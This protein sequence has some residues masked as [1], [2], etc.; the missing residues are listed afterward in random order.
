MRSVRLM[1]QMVWEA[2][3]CRMG[4]RLLTIYQLY[5]SISVKLVSAENTKQRG[6][7]HWLQALHAVH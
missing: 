6:D 2:A 4:G 5:V 7:C 3:A 1:G